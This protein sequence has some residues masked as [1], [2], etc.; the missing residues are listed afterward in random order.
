MDPTHTL[1]SFAH[2]ADTVKST[3]LAI[4]LRHYGLELR[5]E[6]ATIARNTRD[7]APGACSRS[8]QNRVTK[9][10][11]TDITSDRRSEMTR[12][13]LALTRLTGR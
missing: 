13:L 10:C 3:L 6:P 2:T 4:V 11:T 8:P 9:R 5:Q 12:P 1:N 7:P